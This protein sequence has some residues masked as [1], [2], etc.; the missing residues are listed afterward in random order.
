[1]NIKSVFS[2]TV[3]ESTILIKFGTID[4][5]DTV[6]NNFFVQTSEVSKIVHKDYK[7]PFND[8]A[9]LKVRIFL[10]IEN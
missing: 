8:I 4:T 5:T 6:E 3:K 7:F 9:L 10:N 1:M 2:T